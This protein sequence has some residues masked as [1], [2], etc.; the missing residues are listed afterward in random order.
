MA[1]KVYD[2]IPP[3]LA[4]KIEEDVREYL[5][6]EK[7]RNVKKSVK[8]SDFKRPGGKRFVWLPISVV[9]IIVLLIAGGYLFFKLPKANIDIWP[10]VET[11]SYQTSLTADASE[12]L[13]DIGEGVIPAQ[14]FEISKTLSEEFPAT[15][16][17]NDEGK[18][19]GVITIYNKYDPPQ[20]VT[21]RAGTHFLSDS[22]KLFRASERIVIPAAKKSGSKITPGSVQVEVQAVEGGD[23]YNIPASNFSVPGLKGTAFYYSIYAVSESAMSGGYTGDIKKVTDSDIQSAKDNLIEKATSEAVAELES[24]ISSDY[25]LLENAISS[26]ITESGAQTESGTVAEKFTYETT[27]KVSA[28][29]FRK[30][31]L[32]EF[33][34]KYVI[35]QMPEDRTLLDKSLKISYSALE[36]DIEGGTVALDFSFSSGIFKGIDKNSVSMA[37]EGKD[38]NQIN[39]TVN[40]MLGD[41]VFKTE[42]KFWPFWVSKAPKNQKAI[43]VTLKFE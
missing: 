32:E 40:S 26:E 22:G 9:G 17:A 39:E 10:K 42:V 33:A 7:T 11:L 6:E 15:G 20:S 37:L 36:V 8:Q 31:D 23:S 35:S 28:L 34:K 5:R 14:H 18:A 19:S 43:N 1:K 29:G 3:K 30:S 41:E 13:T 12:N 16:N 27:I 21:F 4:R 38:A 24:Q 2:V 25:I